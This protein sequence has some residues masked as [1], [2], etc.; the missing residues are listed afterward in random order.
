MSL[1]FEHIA[2]AYENVAALHDI[3]FTAPSGEITCLLGSSG[4][5]KSTLLGLA[6]G[7]LSV[8][9]GR[10]SVGDEVLAEPGMNPP[11]E[12]RPVGLVFQDGA[13]FP[14]MTIAQN[15]GFGLGSSDQGAVDGWLEAVGLGGLG[16]RYP[17]ELSGGQQQRAALARAMAPGPQV[18][19]MDEPFAS[20]DIV[21]RRR[22]RRDCRRLLRER[23]ATTVLVTHDPEEALD[24]AD[25]I[26]V[27][28]AGRIVQFGTPEELHEAPKAASA[29]AIFGGAQVV[30]AKRQG[31]QFLTAFGNW[32]VAAVSGDVPDASM[33]DLLVHADQLDC[34]PDAEGLALRDLQPLGS[35]TR[36]FLTGSGGE[37]IAAET[38][39]TIDPAA[40]YR[41][42]PKDLSLR[43]FARV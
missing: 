40:R 39:D 19:L 11:P 28:D 33:L 30:R 21:L 14:H 8:Q 22:L 13:L 32:P 17:H 31:E 7:L 36:V 34:V 42:Q 1:R 27:M 37:E 26:A 41:L 10:V 5:G 29:G 38:P 16:A 3:S 15:V 6:A 9:R 20:V 25:R 2:H 18:L 12:A 24:V 35:A 4:C 23:G 43:A